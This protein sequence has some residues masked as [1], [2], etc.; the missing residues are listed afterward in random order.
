MASNRGPITF[1]IGEDGAPVER[2]GSGG[3][4]TALS[5]VF[6]RD[7]IT[8]ISSAM[9]DADTGAA[10]AGRELMVEP[11]LRARF[12]LIPADRYESY[13]NKIA[14]QMLWFAHHCL[15]DI[16]RSPIFDDHTAQDW[17]AFVDVNRAFAQ[18]LA[19]EANDPVFLIQDYH[20]CLVP[21]M[22]RELRPE[23]KIVHFS[24]TPFAAPMYLRV[25]PVE[26]RASIVR[27]MAGAD[28]IGFQSR[29]WGE[30]FLLSA[31]G[32]SDVHVDQ[33]RG[34][35]ALGG[36]KAYV[37][38]FPVSVNAA[39]LR[40]TAARPELKAI[41]K[42]IAGSR[43][44]RS[45]LLRV[46][47]LEPSKNILR[48]FLAFELFLNRHPSWR[49]RVT[50]MALLSPSREEL[51]EYQTYAE[52]CLAQAKRI[53]MEFATDDWEPI[54]V[55]VQEDYEYAVAA[56]AN[57]DALIVNPVYDGMNLVA[58]EGPLVNRR[59]G[60]LI[61]SRN[62]G[63]YSR[64]GKH[65]LPVNPF[66]LYE[67]AEAIREALEMPPEERARRGRGLSRSVQAHTPATW[68]TDQLEALDRVRA[69]IA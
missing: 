13:Y 14:N 21:E 44:G 36:R 20:L 10:R 27:G 12:V 65:A 46:D 32:L 64:L 61:L 19:Q 40:E 52:E 55:R 33:R 1:E 8:W 38:T 62:A 47:R 67:T 4:V 25:L 5:D 35:L 31:Q 24:H 26:M 49:R 3:L 68:L 6:L 9:S 39:S 23:A 45:L 18:S 51:D 54:D 56:Y 66:D 7:D 48:G 28:V 15:W 43:G 58:M 42:E 16:A 37:R 17:Q 63:A 53:N 22:L 41:A 50:F 69:P 11:G 60:V 29:A 30:N 34:R 59:Q 57:Y 2:R